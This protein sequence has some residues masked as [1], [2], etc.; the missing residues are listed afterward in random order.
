MN[1]HL[2]YALQPL[3]MR[4][5]T[6]SL[7]QNHVLEAL[8]D[9]VWERLSPSLQL[10]SLVAGK[11][12]HGTGLGSENIYFPTQSVISLQYAMKN[13]DICEVGCIGYESACGVSMLMGG[14]AAPNR[15]VVRH[16]GYA[17]RIPASALRR[18]F[19][20]GGPVNGLMMRCV[21]A[22]LC[23]AAQN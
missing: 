1:D 22:Q 15:A 7:R 12:L 13:G 8:P 14:E 20:L 21:Q 17:F 4:S 19:E 10:V 9:D 5:T 6:R 23:Q 11:L 16:P 18:E 2:H 3:A